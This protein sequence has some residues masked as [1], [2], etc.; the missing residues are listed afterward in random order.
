MIKQN[1]FNYVNEQA[2]KYESENR[3]NKLDM[4]VRNVNHVNQVKE[5]QKEEPRTFAKTG[6]AI[7]RN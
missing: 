5:L 1:E 2:T 7:I 4:R 6:I 3:K